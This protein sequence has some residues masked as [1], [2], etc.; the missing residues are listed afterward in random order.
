[1]AGTLPPCYNPAMSPRPTVLNIAPPASGT[2]GIAFLA[3]LEQRSALAERYRLIRF[4][5]ARRD[6]PD[7]TPWHR[8]V[9]TVDRG[10][11]LVAALLRHRP[12][13]AQIHT[14]SKGSFWSNA[15]AGRICLRL[16]CPFV[17]RIHGGAFADFLEELS[18]ERRAQAGAALRSARA[19][20]FL[21]DRWAER[22]QELVGELNWTVIPNA[23][24]FPMIPAEERPARAPDTLV[25]FLFIGT[26][27]P[28]KGLYELIDAARILR[29][30]GGKPPVR[31]L[32]VGG[33][34]DDEEAAI[35]AH[36]AK[37]PTGTMEFAGIQ[38]GEGKLNAFR[39]ADALLLPSHTE[40]QPLVILEAFAAGLP[41]IATTV[42]AIPE[43]IG[44]GTHGFL[45]PP[46]D[47]EAIAQAVVRLATDPALRQRM[48]ETNQA[49]FREQYTL[50]RYVERV[51]RHWKQALSRGSF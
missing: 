50:E 6:E 31:F 2:G 4:P 28:L 32:I 33:G 38:R 27:R 9:R 8:L 49:R 41:V 37:D 17:F 21:S 5:L 22:I 1:M 45:I 24:E 23:V 25:T 36:Y 18:P 51:D 39:Q 16:G 42:G 3:D 26:L 20:A 15:A 7:R 14:A 13:L 40:G 35:R 29:D 19:V 30:R 34:R 47:P 48:G 43:M 46:R 11:A 12:A 44:E 10:G